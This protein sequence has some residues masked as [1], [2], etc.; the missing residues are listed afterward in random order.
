MFKEARAAYKAAKK[1]NAAEY[2]D[3]LS[4]DAVLGSA[5][6]PAQVRGVPPQP[7]C[8]ACEIAAHNPRPTV[9]DT[10]VT[11]PSNARNRFHSATQKLRAVSAFQQSGHKRRQRRLADDPT[12][13]HADAIN[14][15]D[16]DGTPAKPS[17]RESKT[18]REIQTL[19]SR[20]QTVIARE[21]KCAGSTVSATTKHLKQNPEA[22][23]AVTAALAE[24]SKLAASMGPKALT[25]L[26][27]A[28]PAAFALMASPQFLVAA[29]VGIGLT[30]V[31]V[32]GYK[33][34]KRV[35]LARATARQ[36]EKERIE[37]RDSGGD[38]DDVILLVELQPESG[39]RYCDHTPEQRQNGIRDG[40][41]LGNAAR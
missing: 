26:K 40:D 38:G 4:R 17:L 3:K 7:Y 22:M 35:R 23:A 13:L 5:E 10:G 15:D 19:L 34:V 28:F 32:G 41:T 36:A 8:R 18:L 14:K 39:P 9:H 30:V 29:G 24:A 12:A 16:F 21:T 27:I 37:A 25:A 1:K 31:A 11:R 33:V 6:Q 2:N 20:A